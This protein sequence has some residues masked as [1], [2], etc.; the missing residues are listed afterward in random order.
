MDAKEALAQFNHWVMMGFSKSET[1]DNKA[2]II[3]MSALELQIPMKPHRYSWTYED[4]VGFCPNCDKFI[5][6]ENDPYICECGQHI[7]WS[8]CNDQR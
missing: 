1:P 8:D 6:E 2:L 3:A 7:D 4:L 5:S